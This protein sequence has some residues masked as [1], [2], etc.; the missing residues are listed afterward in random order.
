M[1]LDYWKQRWKEGRTGWHLSEVNPKLIEYWPQLD[2]A[3]GSTIF[4]PLCGSSLDIYWLAEQGFNV[5]G[6]DASPIAVGNIVEDD[7][8][9]VQCQDFFKLD[10]EPFM[11]WYD[12]A[13]LVALTPRE[14]P[15]YFSKLSKLLAIGAKGLLVSFEYPKGHR[16]GP[17]F[18]VNREEI[19]QLC[20]DN[21][22]YTEIAREGDL[23]VEVIYELER[24]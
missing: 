23:E 2:I 13:A 12:R 6:V 18:S 24:I 17:P 10:H 4:V 16:S 22:R 1:Q 15:L 20:N 3:A 7:C 8:I 19:S 9:D 21:F 11:A 14:R 5:F